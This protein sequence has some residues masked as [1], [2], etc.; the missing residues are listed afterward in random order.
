MEDRNHRNSSGPVLK[1]Y[2][3]RNHVKIEETYS[4]ERKVLCGVPQD[5]VHAPILFII[6]LNEI[7]QLNTTGNIITMK[8]SKNDN[9][10]W[11]EKNRYLFQ[12][13][14]VIN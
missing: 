10:K 5:T 14:K 1:L 9:R 11:P 3:K 8:K 2:K 4:C 12:F 7:Y 13:A 6:Y